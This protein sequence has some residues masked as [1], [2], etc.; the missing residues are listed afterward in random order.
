MIEAS[1]NLD[2]DPLI[3][4]LSRVHASVSEGMGN[5]DLLNGFEQSMEVYLGG[6]RV[7][8]I[9]NS[10][11]GGEWKPL[12]EETREERKKQGFP[13]EKPILIRYGVLFRGL[14]RGMPGNVFER[15]EDGV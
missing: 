11:G 5:A 13:P 9:A 10:G 7:R 8:Y 2:V 12:A 1:V 15:I 14:Y 4:F 6:M 3:G